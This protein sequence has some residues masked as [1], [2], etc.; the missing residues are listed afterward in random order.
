MHGPGPQGG[1]GPWRTPSAGTA[2]DDEGPAPLAGA[3]PSCRETGRQAASSSCVRLRV[4]FW[5]SG[6]PG[7]FVVE[8]VAL[9]M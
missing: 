5:S 3:G 6:M 1:P 4:L 2:G 8:M 7:P 9:V